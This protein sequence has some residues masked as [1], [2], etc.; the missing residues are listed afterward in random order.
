MMV[1]IGGVGWLVLLRINEA[2]AQ[3]VRLEWILLASWT[4]V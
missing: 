2:G 1:T 4:H 3:V